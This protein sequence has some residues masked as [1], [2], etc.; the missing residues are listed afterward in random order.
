MLSLSGYGEGELRGQYFGVVR[1]GYLYRLLELPSTFGAGIYVGGWLEARNVWQTSK[2]I[3]DD[4]VYTATLAT[5][6]DTRFGVLYF[7]YGVA[8]DGKGRFFLRL[9][10]RF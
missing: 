6:A 7:G 9:G 3:G 5:G 8:D 10:Q 2:A 1:P 4:L